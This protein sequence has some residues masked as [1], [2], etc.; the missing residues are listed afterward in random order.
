MFVYLP[1]NEVLTNKIA[2]MK[3]LI[4]LTLSV[5]FVNISTAVCT[6]LPTNGNWNTASNWSCGHVPTNGDFVIIPATQICSVDVV[7]PLLSNVTIWVYGKIYFDCGDKIRLACNS[8][9]VLFTGAIMDGAC[10]GSK[11]EYCG[12]Y[13]WTGN[14][15]PVT[16]PA[17]YPSS[18][19]PIELVSFTGEK[20]SGYN[21]FNW[22]TATESN[23][24][25]FTLERSSD[26]L[27]WEVVGNVNGAGNSLQ[28]LYYSFKDLTPPSNLNYYRLKQTDFD[29]HYT[30]SQ[31]IAID[32]S[33]DIMSIEI[34]PNP[35]NDIINLSINSK[36][37]GQTT[38]V[39]TDVLGRV[40][41]VKTISYNKGSNL[42]QISLFQFEKG[43]Y[44]LNFPPFNSKIIKE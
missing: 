7:T 31:I 44:F 21:Q 16:G 23:N 20:Y 32:N 4:L 26:A 43:I 2:N 6:F 13:V 33:S 36:S 5:L 34:Y 27:H 41:L 15:G 9:L 1:L 12:S 40:I 35:T 14:D 8:A 22:I 25:Y 39:L 28:T 10:N 29:G 17:A 3:K 24:D 30:Y 18:S 42:L 11:L 19:L 37:D 38:I